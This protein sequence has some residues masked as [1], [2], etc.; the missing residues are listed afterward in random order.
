MDFGGTFTDH[1]P[2]RADAEGTARNSY[3]QDDDVVVTQEATVSR[4]AAAPSSM[5][6]TTAR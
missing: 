5:G 1:I 6:P 2:R 4:A 3:D